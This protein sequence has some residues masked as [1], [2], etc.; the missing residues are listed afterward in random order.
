MDPPKDIV[1]RDISHTQDKFHVLTLLGDPQRR[2]VG[3]WAPGA[4][5]AAGNSRFHGDRVM[6]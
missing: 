1:L 6:I 5:E 4:W 3:R 2:K